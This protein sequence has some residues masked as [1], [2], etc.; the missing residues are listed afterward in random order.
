M[1][2]NCLRSGG[3]GFKPA[4]YLVPIHKWLFSAISASDADLNPLNSQCIP[5]V[6]IFVFLDLAKNI[7]FLDGHY[8]TEWKDMLEEL[9]VKRFK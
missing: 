4:P 9:E 5:A 8:L 2:A 6:K 1:G 3:V 7:S